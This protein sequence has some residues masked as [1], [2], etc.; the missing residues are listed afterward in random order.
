MTLFPVPAAPLTV[1]RSGTNV[2]FL[3]LAYHDIY[4]FTLLKT[5]YNTAA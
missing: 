3:V 2:P 5:L 1:S 4:S